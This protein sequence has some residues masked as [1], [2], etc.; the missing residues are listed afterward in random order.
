MAKCPKI[1]KIFEVQ[2]IL[3]PKK[4]KNFFVPWAPKR[5]ENIKVAKV[6]KRDQPTNRPTD[7]PTDEVTY[8]TTPLKEGMVKKSVP[9]V[10]CFKNKLIRSPYSLRDVI[11]TCFNTLIFYK[12]L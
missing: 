9:R 12:N 3:K 8:G 10:S 1:K 11:L 7:Q 4:K 2:N 6:E 5:Q